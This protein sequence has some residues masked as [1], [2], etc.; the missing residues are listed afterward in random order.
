M[1]LAEVLTIRKLIVGNVSII[2]DKFYTSGGGIFY[3]NMNRV[4]KSSK[5]LKTSNIK[6]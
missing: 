6:Y 3:S 4:L 1:K 2:F 5:Y